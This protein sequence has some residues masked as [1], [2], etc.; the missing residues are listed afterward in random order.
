[1]PVDLVLRRRER[2][3]YAAAPPPVKP[4]IIVVGP[5]RSGTTLVAQYLINT[6]DVC[7][8]NNLTALFP[9]S[10]ITASIL[11]GR[12]ARLKAGD[13]DAFYGKSRG[14]SGANDGLYIWDRWLGSDR[15]QVPGTLQGD[16]PRTMP[17]FFGA[18]EA[19]Y[20]LPL[21][22]KVN[23]LNTC[24]DLVAKLLPNAWFICLRRDPLYLAQS[25]Y[26]ARDVI[27]GD[28]DTPY[29]TRHSGA[30]PGDPIEDVC[31]Q[32]VYHEE[33]A[34]RQQALLGS[35]RFSVLSYEDFCDRPADFARSVE[36]QHPA[37]RRR[38]ARE[39]DPAAF[40]ISRQSKLPDSVLNRM[41]DTLRNL[42]TEEVSLRSF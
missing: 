33:Q 18:L 2:R 39:P 28:L 22:N 32:V 34:R 15:D 17:Q 10:P 21:V 25:L 9:K 30:T 37:L 40:G 1:M 38:D 13:Y 11:F 12:V 24:A 14:L 36:A 6:F 20:G 35:M 26:V 4:I 5:P 7:Y 8:L 31:R 42:A 19:H 41:K 23:R 29:G 3:L 27:A 16:A